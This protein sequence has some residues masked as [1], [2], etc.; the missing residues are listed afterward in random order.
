MVYLCDFV[1]LSGQLILVDAA[2]DLQA[3]RV[4]GNGNVGVATFYRSLGHLPYGGRPVAPG[5]VHLQVPSHR[6]KETGVLGPN[7]GNICHGEKATADFRWSEL[8]A[9]RLS[10]P[11]DDQLAKIGT[12]ARQLGQ[13]LLSAIELVCSFRP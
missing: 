1:S 9:R 3:L 12:D 11:L 13:A 8:L 5:S 2:G 6:F 10:Q 4:I 7:G